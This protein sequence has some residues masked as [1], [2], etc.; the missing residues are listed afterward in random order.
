[1]YECRQVVE[2]MELLRPPEKPL[3]VAPVGR[4]RCEEIL[5]AGLSILRDVLRWGR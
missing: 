1:M 2:R 5:E 4:E 3:T